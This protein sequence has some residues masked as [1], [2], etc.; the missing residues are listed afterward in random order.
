MCIR[1]G[2]WILI[3]Y[4]RRSTGTL[5]KVRFDIIFSPT[6]QISSIIID[7]DK[8]RFSPNILLRLVGITIWAM[9]FDVIISS[10]KFSLPRQF[11]H[12]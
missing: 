8:H 7:G 11:S 3:L 5:S 10:C 9:E 2:R 1:P 12:G 6:G 4:T